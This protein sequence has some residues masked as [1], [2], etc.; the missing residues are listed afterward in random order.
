MSEPIS[1]L[2]SRLET[3]HEI[4]S[5]QEPWPEIV[6]RNLHEVIDVLRETQTRR[7][8]EAAEGMR[9]DKLMLSVLAI[10]LLSSLFFMFYLIATKNLE[11]VTRVLYPVIM[12][13]LGFMSGYFAGSGRSRGRGR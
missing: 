5:S 10:A 7:H 6:D 8:S 3:D 1:G 13:I 11:A 12:T 9:L 4:A 2:A